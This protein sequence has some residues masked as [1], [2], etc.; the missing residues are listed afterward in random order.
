LIDK[1]GKRFALPDK[2]ESEGGN[3]E[4]KDAFVISAQRDYFLFICAW[5]VRHSGVGLYGTQYEAFLYTGENLGVLNKNVKYSKVFSGY[6]GSLEEGGHNYTWYLSRKIANEKINELELNRSTD[7]LALAH[8]IVL[9]RL[10]NEDYEGIKA[11]LN[12]DRFEQLSRDFP[13][14][15]TNVGVYNDFGYALGRSGNNDLAYKILKSVEV[16]SPN[17]I[18]LKLNIA[19]VLWASDKEASKI[20][21]KKYVESMRQSGRGKLIPRV[22]LDRLSLN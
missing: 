1:S 17:R 20:Y 22:V 8:Q 12:L 13:I 7:S 2:C 10:K 21:Y 15:K 16:V 9:A 5:L 3:A 6:E 4:L 11:Y 19:D 18:V 14:G